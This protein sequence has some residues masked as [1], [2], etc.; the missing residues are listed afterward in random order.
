MPTCNTGDVSVMCQ[1]C[2]EV[3]R[4]PCVSQSFHFS[5][6]AFISLQILLISVLVFVPPSG[7]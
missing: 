5:A 6:S 7:F 2:W 4:G 3:G 1:S